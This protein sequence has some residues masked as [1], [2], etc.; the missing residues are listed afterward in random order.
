MKYE[1]KK[2]KKMN[3]IELNMKYDIIFQIGIAI[4]LTE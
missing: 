1:K 2:K 4:I 3:L